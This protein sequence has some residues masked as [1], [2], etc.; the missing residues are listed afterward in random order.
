MQDITARKQVESNLA[1]LA[2]ISEAFTPAATT[3]QI[4]HI[5]AQK[6][7]RHFDASRVNF[8]DVS[9]SGD[10]ITVFYSQREEHLRE[11]RISHCLSEYLSNSLIGQLRAGQTVAV[12][13]VQTDPQTSAHAA[14]Y[15]QWNI[16]SMIFSASRQ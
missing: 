3:K 16:G 6:I 12:S 9:A 14:A 1:F 15:L 4:A 11:D 2:E 10:K 13:D 8:S 5:A 7:I